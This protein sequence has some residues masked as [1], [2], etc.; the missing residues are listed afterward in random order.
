MRVDECQRV[1]DLGSTYWWFV[2]T[3]H[4]IYSRLAEVGWAQSGS[5]IL[6]V[7]CGSGIMLDKLAAL[8]DPVGIDVVWDCAVYCLNKG[9]RKVCCA[10]AETLPFGTGKFDLLIATDVI[11]HCRDDA[12]ALREFRRVLRPSGRLVISVPAFPF[13]WSDHDVALDHWRRYRLRPLTDMVRSSGFRVRYASYFNSY[14]FPPLAVL[15]TFQRLMKR[16]KESPQSNYPALPSLINRLLISFNAVE[17][18]ILRHARL[19]FGTSLVLL[20]ECEKPE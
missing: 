20:A 3:R 14:L 16:R 1:F 5:R 6:D 7:G 4:V 9:H 13:L 19:P 8:T 12:G 10:D 17:A 15:R 11:E 2:G 18:R